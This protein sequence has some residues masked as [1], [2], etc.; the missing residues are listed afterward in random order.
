MPTRNLP[1][2][3]NLD[4]LKKQAKTLLKQVNAG[5]PEGLALAAEYHPVTNLAEAQLVI[6]R[7]YG[8][9]SWPKLI[10]HLEVIAQYTRFPHRQEVGGP[11][12]RR[13]PPAGHFALRARRSS[14]PG[15]RAEAAANR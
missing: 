8:F 10:H 14:S 11:T 7:S 2:P 1:N 4:H 13:V 5:D 9:A 6:A 15:S 3:P 12:S